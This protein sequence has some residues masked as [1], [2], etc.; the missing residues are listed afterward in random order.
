MYKTVTNIGTVTGTETSIETLPGTV[1]GTIIETGTSTVTGTITRN[2]LFHR[3]NI[4][5][6]MILVL[7]QKYNCFI[8]L[9]SVFNSLTRI[10]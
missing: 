10:F 1:T 3:F 6:I 2:K 9:C 4:L 5:K 8:N 7:K